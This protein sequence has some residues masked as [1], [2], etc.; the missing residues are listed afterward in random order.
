MIKWLPHSLPP[1]PPPLSLAAYLPQP[2]QVPLHHDIIIQEE[3]LAQPGEHLG[4]VEAQVV[5][6]GEV[7][8]VAVLEVGRGCGG[9]LLCLLAGLEV[10]LLWGGG[11]WVGGMKGK[12]WRDIA[13]YEVKV[14][15]GKGRERL[16]GGGW[17][18]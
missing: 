5:E 12:K 2:A 16:G 11:G 18:E 8:G 15:E 14:K 7:L 17:G 6:H 1:P 13:R 3:D 9:P 4:Q 10:V